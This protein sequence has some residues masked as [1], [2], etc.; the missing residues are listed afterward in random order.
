MPH[1]N[2]SRQ[3]PAPGGPVPRA[4]GRGGGCTCP[5]NGG[6]VCGKHNR[7][8]ERHQFRT[9]RDPDGTWHVT[10]PDGTPVE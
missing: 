6:P 7:F 3:E 8:K 9:C 4:D 1:P 2:P 10:H 5:G